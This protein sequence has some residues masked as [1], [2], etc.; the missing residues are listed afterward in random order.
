MSMITGFS[1]ERTYAYDQNRSPVFWQKEVY[2]PSPY[3]IIV[4]LEEDGTVKAV[5]KCES[6]EEFKKE[7]SIN[8]NDEK[9]EIRNEKKSSYAKIVVDDYLNI[10]KKQQ[11]I[12]IIKKTHC[13]KIYNHK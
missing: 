1:H 3:N 12:E 11:E 5:R 8:Y 6:I 7:L 10:L 2:Y 9:S 13:K 4:S